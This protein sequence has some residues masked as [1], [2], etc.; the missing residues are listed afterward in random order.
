MG[1]S[2]IG[3][4]EYRSD[5]YR[6]FMSDNFDAFQA[7]VSSA[8]V[9]IGFNSLTFDNALCRANGLEVS[10]AKSFDILVEVWRGA[11][12]G[13]AYEDPT[14]AGFGLDACCKANFGTSKSGRGDLAPVDWQHGKIGNV[15]DYCLN[16]VRLTKQLMDQ[17]LSHG[18]IRDPRDPARVLEI[19]SPVAA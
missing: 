17:I 9:V 1:I 4:Y 6:A 7:A 3:A 14:H 5:R 12:L 10:D 16:D 11:G 18:Y 15:V 13:T 19:K 2:V 8:D